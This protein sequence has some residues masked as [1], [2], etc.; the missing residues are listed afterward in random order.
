MR[1]VGF[2]LHFKYFSRRIRAWFIRGMLRL[3]IPLFYIEAKLRPSDPDA[4]KKILVIVIGGLGDCLLFDTLFRRLKAHWPDARI[5]VLTGSFEDLWE[6]IESID[7]L[8][9]FQPTKFK[10]PLKYA[11]LFR[12][13][14]HQRY[15]IVTEG[16]AMVPLRGVFPILSSLVFEASRS[17]VRIGRQ[18]TGRLPPLRPRHMGFQGASH[19][20]E[21]NRVMEKVAS[22]AFPTQIIDLLPPD[23]RSYHESAKV[24]EPLGVRYFRKKDEPM[25]GHHPEQDRWAQM[26]VRTHWGSESDVIV[27]FTIET[28]RK[29]KAWPAEHFLTVVKQGLHDKMRF[30]MLG[31][32]QN[33][34]D[35]PFAK[36]V[37]DRFLD[38]TGRTSLGEMMSVIA[39]CDLFLSCD[40][41][42]AHIAQAYGVPTIVLFGPSNEA[43]F[44]PFDRDRHT[45]IL[46]PVMGGSCMLQIEP[47]TVYHALIQKAAMIRQDTPTNAKPHKPANVLCS[48]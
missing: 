26:L 19:R 31:L 40:T 43:E 28:T 5:D 38:L 13:V 23:K 46:P 36:L 44:G 3:L 45:L 6:R 47:Q 33:P 7:N 41:G 17:P 21:D 39:Q 48:I 2:S 35:S 37:S 24:F 12:I 16:I 27:G 20:S 18:S 1:N 10:S 14:Y 11:S 15:D 30:I 9:Y 32:A 4:R 29:I 25:L 42:P 34:P 8:I 22:K